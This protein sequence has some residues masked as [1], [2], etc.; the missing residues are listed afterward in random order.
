MAMELV[1]PYVISVSNPS[2]SGY[3]DWAKD[4]NDELYKLKF[5]QVRQ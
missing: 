5:E 4:Q 1:W 3:L 2:V